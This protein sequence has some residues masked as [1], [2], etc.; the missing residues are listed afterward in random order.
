MRHFFLKSLLI[1]CDD[2]CDILSNLDL[3]ILAIDEYIDPTLQRNVI[4][5]KKKEYGSIKNLNYATQ[6][7]FSRMLFHELW[8]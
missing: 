1:T 2:R 8:T 5:E 3:V 7:L 6:S 4:L